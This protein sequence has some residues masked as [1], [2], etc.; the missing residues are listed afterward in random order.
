MMVGRMDQQD[1]DTTEIIATIP[2]RTAARLFRCTVAQFYEFTQ[3]SGVCIREVPDRLSPLPDAPFGHPEWG[4]GLPPEDYQRAVEQRR[5]EIP[6]SQIYYRLDDFTI[7]YEAIF[8][9]D[10]QLPK[11][12]TPKID[13]IPAGE[14]VTLSIE[15]L[16]ATGKLSEHWQGRP[17]ASTWVALR[18]FVF[19]RDDYTCLYCGK[20]N[21]KLHC[22]HIIPI[23]KGGT[24]HP[25]NL[26]TACGTCNL[27]KHARTPEEWL[28]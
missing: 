5:R 24:N 14:R 27:V 22:D 21:S 4:G 17:S 8:E 19:D 10:L 1:S 7:M 25:D 26:V 6:F 18:K 13:K 3:D 15:Q 23:C 11:A 9:R 28:S 2:A 16:I 20:P 12:H